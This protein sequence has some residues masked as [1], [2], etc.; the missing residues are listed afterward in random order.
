M[1]H[2]FLFEHE[3]RLQW[4][5]SKCSF[6][7]NPQ[8]SKKSSKLLEMIG[9]VP[10]NFKGTFQPDRHTSPF[11]PGV[12][13]EDPATVAFLSLGVPASLTVVS[14][15]ERELLRSLALWERVNGEKGYHSSQWG[16]E[17]G[18]FLSSNPMRNSRHMS[19]KADWKGTRDNCPPC[20]GGLWVFH[21]LCP[22]N[23]KQNCSAI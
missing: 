6:L 3:V 4:Y 22:F 12:S 21:L 1:N 16:R 13:Q 11:T 10:S 17:K 15:K 2:Y 9:S 14:R 5:L 8:V 7:W 20:T 18:A 23:K 19:I